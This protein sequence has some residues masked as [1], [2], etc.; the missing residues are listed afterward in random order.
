MIVKAAKHVVRHRSILYVLL[1]RETSGCG[2][3]PEAPRQRWADCRSRLLV[4]CKF[5][6]APACRQSRSSL[7]DG[8]DQALFGELSA[9]RTAKHSGARRQADGRVEGRV[10][11]S[12][13]PALA[14]PSTSTQWQDAT[15]PAALSKVGAGWPSRVC[16]GCQRLQ[17]Q[18]A[19]AF[20]GPLGGQRRE[21]LT[22]LWIQG[23]S[24]C[25]QSW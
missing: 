8:S 18:K 21:P 7:L 2:G 14:Q 23:S 17:Q 4:I 6:Q 22:G 3:A 25:M 11:S 12:P 20:S 13:Y 16:R 19:V 15:E 10:G 9:A 1:R 5:Q 24:R